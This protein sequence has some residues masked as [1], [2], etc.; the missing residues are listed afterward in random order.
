MEWTLP[1]LVRLPVDARKMNQEGEESYCIHTWTMIPY[2][3]STLYHGGGG[4]VNVNVDNFEKGVVYISTTLS[5]TVSVYFT[6]S[7]C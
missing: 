7:V 5:C 3:A 6:A 1:V 2:E 4:Y